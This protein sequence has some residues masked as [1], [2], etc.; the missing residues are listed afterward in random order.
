MLD[1][2]SLGTKWSLLGTSRTRSNTEFK[3][4]R[5]VLRSILSQSRVIQA[6][7]NKGEEKKRALRLE[8]SLLFNVS[9]LSLISGAEINLA[10]IQA[11]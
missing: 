4:R 1:F 7:R 8:A 11:I 9:K 5:F 3:S 10:S 2:Q 6:E